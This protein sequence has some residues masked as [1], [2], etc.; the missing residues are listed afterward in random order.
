MK[1]VSEKGGKGQGSNPTKSGKGGA[2]PVPKGQPKVA[3][4]GAFRKGQKTDFAEE[5][6]HLDARMGQVDEVGEVKICEDKLAEVERVKQD[7]LDKGEVVKKKKCPRCEREIPEEIFYDHWNNHSSELFEWLYL[8]GRRNAE[9]EV[10]L[11]KRTAITHILN[12]AVR[13]KTF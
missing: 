7:M 2:P 6:K 13:I 12:V 1:G 5:M 9:N 3:A 11:I 10:E 4:R 8:G